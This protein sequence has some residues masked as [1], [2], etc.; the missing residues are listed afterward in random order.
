MNE[1]QDTD[2]LIDS[3]RDLWA[4]AFIAALP[5]AMQA[6]GWTRDSKSITS[7]EDRVSL[8]ATWADYAC[9]E[10]RQRFGSASSD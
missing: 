5:Y 3:D 9:K 1:E 10:F 2:G 7:G 8:A 6:Q 4:E